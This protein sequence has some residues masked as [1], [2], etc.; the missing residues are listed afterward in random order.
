MAAV[1]AGRAFKVDIVHP[2]IPSTKVGVVL[3]R[4]GRKILTAGRKKIWRVGRTAWMMH[5][6]VRQM[7]GR[8]DFFD[9]CRMGCR[10]SAGHNRKRADVRLNRIMGCLHF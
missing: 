9:F 6:A 10:K 2:V 1:A 4:E 8:G 7:A 5:P 3:G